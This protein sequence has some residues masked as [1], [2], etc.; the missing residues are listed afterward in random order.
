MFHPADVNTLID[1][2][3]RVGSRSSIGPYAGGTESAL[4]DDTVTME[5]DVIVDG[6]LSILKRRLA[7]GKTASET[8]NLNEEANYHEDRFRQ[9]LIRSG[10]PPLITFQGE[11]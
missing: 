8:A 10:Y 5:Q 9:G 3:I 11:R 6:A 4:D 2:I 7:V 1:D